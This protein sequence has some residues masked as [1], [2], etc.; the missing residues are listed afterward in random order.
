MTTTITSKIGSNYPTGRDYAT[1]ATWVAAMLSTYPNLVSSDVVL[2][3][4]LYNDSEFTYNPGSIYV[5][6]SGF[7]TN[8]THTITLHPAAGQGILA[9][10]SGINHLRY[11]IANGVGMRLTGNY[12]TLI[13]IGQDYTTVSGI[14][15]SD[16]GFGSSVAVKLNT[17]SAFTHI[18]ITQNLI[19][20]PVGNDPIDGGSN[21]C[22]NVTKNLIICKSV[23]LNWHYGSSLTNVIG[24]TIVVPSGSS[25]TTAF[26]N[27]SGS[28]VFENNAV[29]GF[30]NVTASTP[31][32]GSNNNCSDLA[33]AWGSGQ[34]A[35]ETY[36]NQFVSNSGSLDFRLKTGSNCINN[37]ATDST[38]DATD[39]VGT[40][41][42]QGA[43]YC[44]GAW[45]FASAGPAFIAAQQ[46]PILQAVNRAG[47]Y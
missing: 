40:S 37:G 46:R 25:G 28:G 24:N 33:I 19:S 16:G 14:Q 5:N 13:Q 11:D 2:V 21:P 9:Q 39:I 22:A 4:E 26:D 10:G 23:A 17:A 36:A 3:G 27:A 42:P 15:F 31:S 18:N 30:T 20:F 43:S 38:Y 8:A 12:G 7:T 45:E 1:P 35:P 34:Q 32:A 47:T 6:I 44:I 29:F 41:R